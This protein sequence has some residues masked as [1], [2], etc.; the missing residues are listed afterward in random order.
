MDIHVNELGA[1]PWLRRLVACL[2]PRRTVF[3]RR[4]VYLGF[5]V[6]EVALEQAFV[7]FL[8]FYTVSIIP[9]WLSTF[10][11]HQRDEQQARKWPQ[12]RDI[13]SPH[14]YKQQTGFVYRKNSVLCGHTYKR[15]QL[16][17]W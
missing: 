8:R 7:R 6:D 3:V 16:N 14:G 4:S 5:V 13:V 9:P 1:A 12:F 2:S 15:T 11:Y 17:K 10:A